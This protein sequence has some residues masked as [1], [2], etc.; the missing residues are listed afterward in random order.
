MGISLGDAF[1]NYKALSRQLAND[2]KAL[3][4]A[5]GSLPKKNET[6]TPEAQKDLSNLWSKSVK[7]RDAMNKYYEQ[8]G[9]KGQ[10]VRF[11]NFFIE[12][13]FAVSK[14]EKLINQLETAAKTKHF[15]L[16]IRTGERPRTSERTGKRPR[17][18]EVPRSKGERP[19]ST[20][21]EGL[22]L[23]GTGKP[24]ETTRY[25]NL[26]EAAQAFNNIFEEKPEDFLFKVGE[27][28]R[29]QSG[30]EK[31]MT[32]NL[33]EKLTYIK[34]NDIKLLWTKDSDINE[35]LVKFLLSDESPEGI[36]KH[37]G[38]INAFLNEEL[39]KEEAA[40]LKE[41][42]ALLKQSDEYLKGK[43]EVIAKSLDD[44]NRK[45]AE[46]DRKLEALEEEPALPYKPAS[47]EELGPNVVDYYQIA[48]EG[49]GYYKPNAKEQYDKA[50]SN[51]YDVAVLCVDKPLIDYFPSLMNKT[52]EARNLSFEK[53]TEGLRN[54]EAKLNKFHEMHP[55]GILK[56]S[57]N[58]DQ[59][60]KL[61]TFLLK[62]VDPERVDEVLEQVGT[63]TE[64]HAVFQMRKE[65]PLVEQETRDIYE[66]MSEKDLD[67]EAAE[68]ARGTIDTAKL[69]IARNRLTKAIS[70]SINSDEILKFDDLINKHLFKN[71]QL[72][73]KQLE[74][75]NKILGEFAKLF[76][77]SRLELS[78]DEEKNSEFIKF[79]FDEKREP[80]QL[81]LMIEQSKVG[82]EVKK[83]PA[84]NSLYHIR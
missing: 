1:S 22:E 14:T 17:T 74:N 28:F 5:I 15:S 19:Q 72:R 56:A 47:A 31:K 79:L 60:R 57:E 77:K 6:I 30:D 10:V 64:G 24:V 83:D 73:L 43:G 36:F 78:D 18:S 82:N 35:G 41:K 16:T 23:T 65:A 70:G 11:L 9:W 76:P 80:A 12:N 48:S 84:G 2:R 66:I 25:K 75:S 49:R 45:L 7:D 50:L 33:E 38:K 42:E 69:N 53:G 46:V 44:V 34:E 62:E 37:I 61:A 40:L 63:D 4:T 51:L 3:S 67:F 68:E 39:I 55:N 71:E 81:V 52:L 27:Q 29:E 59:N 20:G 54:I 8:A 26:N 21:I 32:E 58:N 13:A